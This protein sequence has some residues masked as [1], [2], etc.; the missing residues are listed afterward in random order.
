LLYARADPM[1]PSYVVR[2][3]A[4][5]CSSSTTVRWIERG[6]HM[7]FPSKLDLGYGDVL[8]LENQIVS[9]FLS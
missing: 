9:W 5:G 2:D 6:G 4:L 8:G 1:V 3:A 7:G